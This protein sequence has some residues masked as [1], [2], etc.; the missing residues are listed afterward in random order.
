M[1]HIAEMLGSQPSMLWQQVKQIGV[2]HAVASLPP[3]QG[4]DKPWDYM[5]L[6]RMKTAFEDAGFTVSVIESSPPM[7]KIK[8]GL[9]GRDEEIDIV[10]TMI[11]NMGR[12][13][14]RVWCYNWMAVINWMRTSFTIPARGGAL[15]TGYDHALMKNAPL[16]PY[17]E[18][19]EERLW[20]SLHYF[21][22]RVVPVAESSGV[23]LA[24]HPDDPPLSPLR[25]IG[26]IMRSLDNFQRL[27]D[28]V[29]SP[30]NGLTFCQGNFALMTDDQPAAIRQFGRQGKISF[31]HFRDVHGNPE[32]YEETFHDNGPTDMMACLRAYRDIGFEG[33]LRP[34]HVPTMAGDSNDHPGYSSIGRLFAVGYIL[35]LREAVYREEKG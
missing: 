29:P 34:D 20:E 11:S 35:G 4:N 10:C 9:P 28:L 33:V 19:P 3:A 30:V 6:L 12:L 16:T 1:I 17:G 22:E 2:N 27:V 23:Q 13:G 8:L 32:K 5:P 25:G 24:M 15:V 21:L 14:I 31:V 26:R 18:V 7:D